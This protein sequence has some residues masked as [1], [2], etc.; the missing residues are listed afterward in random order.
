[1]AVMFVNVACASPLTAPARSV[2]MPTSA[3]T[4]S[5]TVCEVYTCVHSE[6]STETQP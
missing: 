4:G 3:V 2:Q 1:M 6:P 5:V